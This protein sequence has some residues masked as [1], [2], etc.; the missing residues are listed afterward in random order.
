MIFHVLIIGEWLRALLMVSQR[1]VNTMVFQE[2]RNLM[3]FKL[4]R[5]LPSL[6]KYS[7][8]PF[9]RLDKP[10]HGYHFPADS[11]LFSEEAVEKIVASFNKRER[12]A[13]LNI[14]NTYTIITR[15]TVG[16]LI[17]VRSWAFSANS[18]F[19]YQ[20][21]FFQ[22]LA[23]QSGDPCGGIPAFHLCSCDDNL[24]IMVR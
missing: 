2:C 12:P 16:S 10:S 22:I 19:H 6:I 9:V 5:M 1:Y 4:Y 14:S 8:F 17:K 11:F 15:A 23:Y 21:H 18:H 13:V 7:Q 20:R 24:F 3:D